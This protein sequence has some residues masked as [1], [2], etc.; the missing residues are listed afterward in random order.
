LV[1]AFNFSIALSTSLT[2]PL[3]ETNLSPTCNNAEPPC[4]PP[5]LSSEYLFCINIFILPVPP[6]DSS[7]NGTYLLGLSLFLPNSDCIMLFFF[8]NPLIVFEN[9][10]ETKSPFLN[11]DLLPANNLP[12]LI[13]IKVFASSFPVYFLS[14]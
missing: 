13:P 7:T 6:L 2:P 11:I 1:S 12:S 14:G 8:K 5:Y 10:G 9:V 4:I 3:T